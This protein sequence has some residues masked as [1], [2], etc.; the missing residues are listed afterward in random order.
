MLKY[1]LCWSE[2]SPS[3][4]HMELQLACKSILWWWQEFYLHERTPTLPWDNRRFHCRLEQWTKL[5]WLPGEPPVPSL[6]TFWRRLIPE[7]FFDRFKYPFDWSLLV[8]LFPRPSYIG[9]YLGAKYKSC[10]QKHEIR[11]RPLHQRS[12]QFS[13]Q[14]SIFVFLTA[15]VNSGPCNTYVVLHQTLVQIRSKT[16][17]LAVKMRNAFSH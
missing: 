17:S 5:W 6:P 13:S 1:L 14:K 16:R 15:S 2:L 7:A 8:C 3:M 9:N 10:T 11:W 12:I 4:L